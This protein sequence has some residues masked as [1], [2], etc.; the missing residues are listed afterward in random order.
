MIASKARSGLTPLRYGFGGRCSAVS[1][2]RSL[3]RLWGGRSF[4]LRA[5]GLGVRLQGSLRPDTAPLRFFW[6]SAASG[7]R[8]LSRLWEGGAFA[9]CARGLGCSPPRLA[10]ARHRSATVLVGC[11]A[12][13]VG[14]LLEL[15][16]SVLRSQGTWGQGK[17]SRCA[18]GGWG[19]RL[20]G[21]LWP[22]TAPLRFW[23]APRYQAS[24]R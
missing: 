24:A 21:S 14:G 20:Q 10:P 8:S 6:G 19:V 16:G 23:W 9:L 13:A 17:L 12:G 11:A 2:L 18:R 3:S 15:C 1:G 22:D 5:R 4:A 7:L